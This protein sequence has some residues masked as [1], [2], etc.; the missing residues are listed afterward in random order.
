MLT[1]Y[2][3]M[4]TPIELINNGGVYRYVSKPWAEE[5]LLHIIRSGIRKY[6]LAQAEKS[7]VLE[8]DRR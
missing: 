1:G 7:R 6:I 2:A 8:Q 3:S 5:E 4:T